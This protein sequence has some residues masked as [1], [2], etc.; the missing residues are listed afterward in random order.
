MF[1]GEVLWYPHHII[2]ITVVMG[3]KTLLP[4]CF[5]PAQWQF[6]C[7]GSDFIEARWMAG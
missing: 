4:H 6:G 2:H 7:D 3:E 5:D 1:K